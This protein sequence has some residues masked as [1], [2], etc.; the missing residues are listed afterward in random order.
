VRICGKDNFLESG[1]LIVTADIHNTS[2]APADGIKVPIDFAGL[3][4]AAQ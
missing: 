2:E 1:S 3:K 4:K